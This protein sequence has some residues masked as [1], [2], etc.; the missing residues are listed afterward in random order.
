MKISVIVPTYKPQH[1]LAECL[2]SLEK[3]TLAK[4]HYEVIIVLNGCS[5]P[6]LGEV[7]ALLRAC[8]MHTVLIHT[9]TPGV[10]HARNMGIARA[11]GEYLV[12]IDDDDW[13][14]E[15]FLQRL[16]ERTSQRTPAVV[17][18][19]VIGY[20]DET[21]EYLHDYYLARLFQ[22]IR[23]A[24]GEASLLQGRSFLSSSCFKLIPRKAIGGRTFNTKFQLGEDALFM[25]SLTN[26]FSSV[27]TSAPDAVYYRR[28]RTNS[29]SHA[30]SRQTSAFLLKNALSLAGAYTKVYLQHP[31]RYNPLFFATRILAGFTKR[32][33]C[34]N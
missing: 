33:F 19:N 28:L 32:L 25:A 13:V 31:F 16:L 10:S 26:C 5:E 11:K 30:D 22:R 23:L 27:A 34:Y 15:P 29:A 12:F 7:K 14:S 21:G 20:R 3:Q 6:W 1:Y 9:G 18:S 8:T 4:Q 2:Q 17:T 24:G